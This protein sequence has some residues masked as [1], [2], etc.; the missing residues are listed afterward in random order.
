M[1]KSKKRRRLKSLCMPMLQ[2]SV[3]FYIRF[4]VHAFEQDLFKRNT[5]FKL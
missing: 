5:C 1:R 3:G 4:W 2:M